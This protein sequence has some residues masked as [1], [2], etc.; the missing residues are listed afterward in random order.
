MTKS[1]KP[2][3]ATGAISLV[4]PPELAQSEEITADKPALVELVGPIANVLAQVVA[5]SRLGFTISDDA[6]STMH[7]S[8]G[9]AVIYMV[10]GHPSLAMTEA[11]IQTMNDAL[12]RE[13]FLVLDSEKRAVAA[14]RE[15][16]EQATKEAA[17]AVIAAQVVEQQEALRK[18]QAELAA[19]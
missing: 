8:T 12:S 4:M 19:A 17:K 18:L 5:L 9:S 14:A 6:W 7:A 16:E 10:P 15:R 3:A 13:Q 11:A 2:T 1:T